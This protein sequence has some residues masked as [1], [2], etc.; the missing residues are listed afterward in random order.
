MSIPI[1]QAGERAHRSMTAALG[2]EEGML[3]SS[4]ASVPKRK[5]SIIGPHLPRGSTAKGSRT[6]LACTS[7]PMIRSPGIFG[8]ES[9]A[10]SAARINVDVLSS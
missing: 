8:L 2:C 3:N 9:D 1:G 5:R 10:F 6:T 7:S 4:L